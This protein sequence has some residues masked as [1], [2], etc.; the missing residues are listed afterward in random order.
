MT[1]SLHALAD[2][3]PASIR[4]IFRRALAADTTVAWDRFHESACS[5]TIRASDPEYMKTLEAL[6]T[7]KELAVNACQMCFARRESGCRVA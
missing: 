7:A 4:S 2:R 3:L 5:V 6:Q 1:G